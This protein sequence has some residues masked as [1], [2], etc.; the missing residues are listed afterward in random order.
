MDIYGEK[1]KSGRGNNNADVLKAGAY[2]ICS[3]N[4]KDVS[5]GEMK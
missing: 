2:L 1:K 5:V 4:N 3:G